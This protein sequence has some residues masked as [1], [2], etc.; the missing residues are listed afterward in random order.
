MI[1]GKFEK[2]DD[3]YIGSIVAVALHA[4]AVRFMP[5]PAKQGSGPDL[6]VLG[7]TKD[8]VSFEIGAAWKKTSKAG[9]AYLSVK[10][11]GPTL[12]APIHCALIE[13]KRADLEPRQ[14]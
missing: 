4:T 2:Q 8:G 7:Y 14:P 11:D 6:V 5:V 3:G 1:I 9:K 12:S 10:L 13:Q